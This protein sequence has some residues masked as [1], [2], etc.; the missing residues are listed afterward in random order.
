MVLTIISLFTLISVNKVVDIDD[1]YYEFSNK[2][3][4]YKSMALANSEDVYF[5]E[6]IRFNNEGNVNMARTIYF[7]NGKKIIVE[8]GYGVLSK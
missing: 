1:T 4:F 7:E 2:Y 5:N 6:N 8:L 3:N